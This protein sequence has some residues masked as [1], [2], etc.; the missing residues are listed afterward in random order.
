M[1]FCQSCGKVNKPQGYISGVKGHIA[2]LKVDE[3]Q[4]IEPKRDFNLS[5][6]MKKNKETA[7]LSNYRLW[8]IVFDGEVSHTFFSREEKGEKVQ[9]KTSGFSL[10]V[11]DFFEK[12]EFTANEFNQGKVT[13]PFT[14]VPKP[15]ADRV[16][17]NIELVKRIK[18]GGD[19]SKGKLRVEWSKSPN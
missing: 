17:V 9:G 2:E 18:Q 12:A 6:I 11:A 13:I 10:S 1:M 4:L 8:V 15:G 16:T 19:K 5:F 14:I 3:P 7:N